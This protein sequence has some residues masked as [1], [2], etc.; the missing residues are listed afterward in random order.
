MLLDFLSSAFRLIVMGRWSE[1]ILFST[2]QV[3][4]G[5]RLEET[6]VMS[7]A[8]EAK[9]MTLVGMSSL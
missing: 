1:L 4:V 3:V 8:V 6:M 7:G 5:I 2:F 9:F